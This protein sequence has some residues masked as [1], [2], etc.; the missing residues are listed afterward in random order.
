MRSSCGGP[1][2]VAIYG[3][4]LNIAVFSVANA[5]L[6]KGFGGVAQN[7]RLL[8]IFT[9]TNGRGGCV[10]YPDFND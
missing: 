9:Q 8:Y 3:L 1:R 5:A 7:D 4:G 2:V 6:C 10:S